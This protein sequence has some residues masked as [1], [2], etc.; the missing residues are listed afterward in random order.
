M[1]ADGSDPQLFTRSASKRNSY[2]VWSPDGR[3]ILFTQDIPG[4]TLPWLAKAGVGAE[5]TRGVQLYNDNGAPM[6]KAKYS[7]DGQWIVME[8]WLFG[9]NHDIFMLLFNGMSLQR[10]TDDR[11]LDFD[12]D[13]RP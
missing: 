4:E 2:P 5:D 3:E 9:E 12:P 13:W 10:L 1:N 6:R 7:P 8:A 11:A